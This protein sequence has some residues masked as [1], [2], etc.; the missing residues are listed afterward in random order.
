MWLHMMH[1]LLALI[2]RSVR[3]RKKDERIKD[4]TARHLEDI[5]ARYEAEAEL[6]MQKPFQRRR[7]DGHRPT[8]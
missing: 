5:V 2:P 8:S 7:H 1:H 3:D 4:A 6:S